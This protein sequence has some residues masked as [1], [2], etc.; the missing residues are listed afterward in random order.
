MWFDFQ[1][2]PTLLWVVALIQITTGSE[3][4]AYIFEFFVLRIL[5]YTLLYIK[6]H[7]IIYWLYKFWGFSAIIQMDLKI[8]PAVFKFYANSC[9]VGYEYLLWV[10][11]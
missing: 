6:I 10:K 7:P 11:I 8:I 4:M 1:V 5:K 2:N 9:F 3:R